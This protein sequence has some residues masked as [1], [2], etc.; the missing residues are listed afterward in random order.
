MSLPELTQEDIE[1]FLDAL[2]SMQLKEQEELLAD[3]EKWQADNAIRAARRDFLAFC[4]RVYPGFK[5]GPLHR[6]LKPILLEVQ[7][8]TQTRLT[9]SMQPRLG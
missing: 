2:P 8:G 5:E 4:H 1:K 3:I 9:V 6:F 7:D